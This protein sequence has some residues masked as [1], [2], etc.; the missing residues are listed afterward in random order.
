MQLTEIEAAF[1]TLRSDL[2]LRP[3][4]HHVPLRIEAHILVRFLAYCLA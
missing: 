1:R 4:L 2:Q 3:I